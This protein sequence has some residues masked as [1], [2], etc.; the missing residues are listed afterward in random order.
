[1]KSDLIFLQ[2]KFTVRKGILPGNSKSL[3]RAVKIAKNHGHSVIPNNMMLNNVDVS[4]P[5][6]AEQFAGFFEKKVRLIVNETI[7]DQSVYSGIQKTQTADEM[8]MTSIKI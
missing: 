5:N 3:W 8:F 2:E 1:M 4:G 7:V 6:I